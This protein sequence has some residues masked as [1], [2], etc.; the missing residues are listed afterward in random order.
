MAALFA[1]TGENG[2]IYHPL[3]LTFLINFI[4]VVLNKYSYKLRLTWVSI[5]VLLMVGCIFMIGSGG[6]RK[7]CT[8]CDGYLVY[9]LAVPL[10]SII[11]CIF[12]VYKIYRNRQGSI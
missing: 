5:S 1:L 11:S 7:G 3:N 2:E 12:G 6:D 9:I 10:P 4:V 8:A